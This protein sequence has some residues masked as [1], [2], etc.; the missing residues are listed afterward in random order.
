MY[1]CEKS[2]TPSLEST[3]FLAI[4]LSSVTLAP[5]Q[6]AK[7]ITTDLIDTSNA[8]DHSRVY[9]R[10]RVGV[11]FMSRLSE[12]RNTS[13]HH[14]LFATVAALTL[15]A[16]AGTY[17]AQ[18]AEPADASISHL[19]TKANGGD[20]LSQRTLGDRYL[21]GDGVPRD[22][23]QSAKWY[24]AAATQGDKLSQFSL[25]M[26]LKDGANGL[27]KNLTEAAQWFRAAAEQGDATS[28]V[29]LADMYANGDGVPKDPSEA[30][31]WYIKATAQSSN[32]TI[33][34]DI[35]GKFYHGYGVPK[36]YTEAEKWARKSAEQGLAE[37]QF[38]MGLMY[39]NG[40]GV[41][42]DLAESARWYR[43][44]A[45]Q[46]YAPAQYNLGLQLVSGSGVP[47]DLAQAYMW[48]NL[49]AVSEEK[50]QAMRSFA[51]T[52]M[53]Q[54]EIAEGQRLTREWLSAHQKTG[55]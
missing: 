34:L 49:A 6:R 30:A 7:R 41:P 17:A 21:N 15:V 9:F 42:T 27:Q 36:D 5:S 24:R 55:K 53:S 40:E 43:K 25:G 33:Q 3:S 48:F 38:M 19:Q 47:K 26:L 32:P 13:K 52:H 37:A 45:D 23:D 18:D 39:T 31:K 12:C 28:Q 14:R 44:A 11:R 29:F 35:A 51:E 16:C 4:S 20:I 1:A 54:S 22:W 10:C 46:G 50:A 2:S 8:L